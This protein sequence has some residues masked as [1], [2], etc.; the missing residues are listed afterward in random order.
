MIVMH[1]ILLGEGD[2]PPKFTSVTSALYAIPSD[3]ADGNTITA[4]NFRDRGLER[5]VLSTSPA[6]LA[7]DF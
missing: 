1:R 3:K 4:F 7:Q 2:L 5:V 6:G